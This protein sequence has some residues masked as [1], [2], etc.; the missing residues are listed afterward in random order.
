MLFKKKSFLCSSRS[1]STK[2]T[3]EKSG[4]YVAPRH[5]RRAPV[6]NM[7]TLRTPSSRCTNSCMAWAPTPLAPSNRR[8]GLQ[9]PGPL[10]PARNFLKAS[11]SLVKQPLRLG[12]PYPPFKQNNQSNSS[13]LVTQI[14]CSTSR[15]QE[16]QSSVYKKPTAFCKTESISG[17]YPVSSRI[18]VPLPDTKATGLSGQPE[19]RCIPTPQGVPVPVWCIAEVITKGTAHY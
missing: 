2:K 18:S 11:E 14:F 4:H 16:T 5:M 1:V 6:L 19:I 8:L 15:Q 10:V 17:L 13:K 9:R 12:S 7:V 3:S